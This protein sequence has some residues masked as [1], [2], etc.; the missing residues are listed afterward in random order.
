MAD[1]SSDDESPTGAELPSGP[2]GSVVSQV[3][4]S[5]PGRCIEFNQAINYVNKIKNRFS[6]SV[7]VYRHFLEILHTYQKE[8]KTIEEVYEQV[9]KLFRDH[10]DLLDEFTHFLPDSTSIALQSA[11]HRARGYSRQIAAP[12]AKPAALQG[13]STGSKRKQPSSLVQRNQVAS[14]TPVKPPTPTSS[15]R[16]KPAGVLDEFRESSPSLQKRF[17]DPSRTL[18][19]SAS[20]AGTPVVGGAK[21]PKPNKKESRKK[22][23]LSIS[24]AESGTQGL[25]TDASGMANARLQMD[26]I[27]PS[28]R[29]ELMFFEHIREKL[30]PQGRQIYSEFIKCLS[31]FSKEIISKQELVMLSEELFENHPG[32]YRA[33]TAYLD[34]VVSLK[35]CADAARQVLLKE[36]DGAQASL[37]A[38]APSRLGSSSAAINASGAIGPSGMEASEATAFGTTALSSPMAS[39]STLLNT[40]AADGM[41][42]EQMEEALSNPKLVA[43]L[44]AMRSRPMSEIAAESAQKSTESYKKLPPDFPMPVCSGKLELERKTL[45]D[46]WVSVPTGSEDYS[47]KQQRKNQYEEN[48]FRCEDDRYELDMVIE[49]N[50]ST[51]MRLEPIAATISKLSSDDKKRH[52]LAAGALGPVHFRAIERIYGDHG[53]EVVEQ[54]RLNPAVAIPVVLQRLKQ[55]DEHWRRARQEM[56][57]IWREVCD[58]N[59]LKSLDHR[60]FIFKQADK[61]EW[62][63]KALLSELLDSQVR[64]SARSAIQAM[65]DENKVLSFEALASVPPRHLNGKESAASISPASVTELASL[66]LEQ[67]LAQSPNAVPEKQLY[68]EPVTPPAAGMAVPALPPVAYAYASSVR[69]PTLILPISC[70]TVHNNIYQVL[71]FSL[72]Y[73]TVGTASDQAEALAAYR[74]VF[75]ALFGCKIGGASEWTVCAENLSDDNSPETGSHSERVVGMDLSAVPLSLRTYARSLKDVA[76]AIENLHKVGDDEMDVLPTTLDVV[77]SDSEHDRA[78]IMYGDETFYL[79]IRA[80]RGLH[81]R[82][83]AARKMAQD[84]AE[85]E[86]QRRISNR[87]EERPDEPRLLF[88]PSALSDHAAH[89]AQVL[90]E[91]EEGL[92]GIESQQ[93][94]S[95]DPDASRRSGEQA[96]DIADKVFQK[97]M[98]L[99]QAFLSVSIDASVYEDRCRELLGADSYILFT[100]DKLVI[101]FVKLVQLAFGPSAHSITRSLAKLFLYESHAAAMSGERD[102]T[103][104]FQLALS[105]FKSDQRAAPTHVFRVQ[106]LPGLGN[107]PNILSDGAISFHAIQIE[108]VSLIDTKNTLLG[109]TNVREARGGS[110]DLA[111]SSAAVLDDIVRFPVNH[112]NAD[113]SYIGAREDQRTSRIGTRSARAKFDSHNRAEDFERMLLGLSM[114][115]LT[116]A[117]TQALEPKIGALYDNLVILNG[118]EAEL[119]SESHRLRFK[120]GT[121]DLLYRPSDSRLSVRRDSRVAAQRAAN[122]NFQKW[123]DN[124]IRARRPTPETVAERPPASVQPSAGEGRGSLMSGT[125]EGVARTE[126]TK[127]MEAAPMEPKALADTSDAQ[128]VNEKVVSN[129]QAEVAAIEARRDGESDGVTQSDATDVRKVERPTGTAASNVGGVSTSAGGALVDAGGAASKNVPTSDKAEKEDATPVVENDVMQVDKN[130]KMDESA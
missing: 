122:A 69:C 28:K 3:E 34:G 2:G 59:Y 24:A 57:K 82:L 52:A 77:K 58:K 65:L 84:Q 75:S 98:E 99:L 68:S 60:S 41:T 80:Y 61:K 32:V 64:S 90:S 22:E 26:S 19:G 16:M 46:V 23:K 129:S 119:C 86:Y 18:T 21:I 76:D 130:E 4:N 13:I 40:T 14:S 15:K 126:P 91:H 63:S 121:E 17:V 62:S 9:A 36:A 96:S 101:K 117:A 92:L 89:D 49:T 51:I 74:H 128:F 20:A 35:A 55:K 113:G 94:S 67:W 66:R 95:R 109:A 106:F 73:E 12:T 29:Q 27:S 102:E 83:K 108:H 93:Q 127:P 97:Y 71:S 88:A 44:H 70:D 45:N 6:S 8:Q 50:A 37:E 118:L 48:L 1:I 56:N 125:D 38:R 25:N 123:L 85:R 115:S 100:M 54:V 30:G 107:G 11:E 43:K 33:F 79:L 78:P 53:V 42:V 47:N 111:R 116:T 81:E 87:D 105:C 120:E 39:S 31:L 7:W 124:L 10:P 103:E 110:T 114:R 5:P 72:Q 112:T 104:Y